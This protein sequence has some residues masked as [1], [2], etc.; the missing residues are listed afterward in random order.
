VE[1]RP[2]QLAFLNQ[3][4][5]NEEKKRLMRRHSAGGIVVKIAQ[6]I[7]PTVPIKGY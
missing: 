3:I 5:N 2:S 7:E 6:Y 4:A 1:N